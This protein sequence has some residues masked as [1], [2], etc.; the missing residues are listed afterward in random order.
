MEIFDDRNGAPKA[1]L[2]YPKIPLYGNSQ[3]LGGSIASN[4]KIYCIPGHATQVMIIDTNTVP[5]N[6]YKFGPHFK[7]EFKWLR[8][9]YTP[10]GM[11]FGL[12]CHANS[13][14]CI[15]SK[16]DNVFMVP[17]N[18]DEDSSSSFIPWKYHG[19][20]YSTHDKCIYLIPQSAP[21]VLKFDTVSL[22][23]TFVGPEFPGKYKWYGGLLGR[24]GAIY[25]I[26]QNASGVLRIDPLA[27]D[28]SEI[29]TI[30]GNFSEGGHKW[31]GGAM[32]GNGVIVSIP[33]NADSVL[34]IDPGKSPKLTLLGN[35]TIVKTGRHRNDKK[36]KFLGGMRDTNGIVYCIPSGAEH[37]LQVDTRKNIVR[38]VGAN[39]FENKLEKWPQNKW[40]NGFTSTDGCMYAIPLNG[41]T[42]LRVQVL[43]SEDDGEEPE[44]VVSTF[45]GPFKG[46]QK[47]EGGVMTEEGVMYCMPNDF[48]A[49]L[50]IE[51]S[52]KNIHS[53]RDNA[54]RELRIEAGC[55]KR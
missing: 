36:Y 19:G 3:Y 32:S 35:E 55:Q 31:H 21:R 1:S 28:P 18:V 41:E 39:I 26:P 33:A 52:V 12:P 17:I 8:G 49:V 15:D 29:V 50:K 46:V 14:L 2:V 48:K 37:V 23:S 20:V 30:H 54:E 9:I 11:I 7:G 47:W 43:N 25:G 10:N 4:K 45:G 6:V 51:P 38:E 5:E 16:N 27:S 13:M 53:T 24:D 22:Q 42:V 34:L 40:Q 44:I